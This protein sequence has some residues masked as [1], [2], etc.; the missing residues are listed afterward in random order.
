MEDRHDCLREPFGMMSLA[1]RLRRLPRRVITDLLDLFSDHYWD[2]GVAATRA[3][4][5]FGSLP[6]GWVGGVLAPNGKIYG[7]PVN[8]TTVL[9]IDPETQ[10]ATTFGSLSGTQKWYG[11]VLAPNGKIYGIPFGSTAV[12]E[13][14]PETQT[15]TTFGSLPGTHK[16]W[17]GVLAPNGKVYGIPLNSAT[18][19]EITSSAILTDESLPPGWILSAYTNKF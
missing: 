9:E 7:I 11:G 2:R 14:D 18:I 10:T 1:Q 4:T 5:T 19:L 6:G 3:T 15:A 17:G 12:L 13:I 8:S 16:W